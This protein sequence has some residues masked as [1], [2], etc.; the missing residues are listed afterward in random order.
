MVK[1]KEALYFSKLEDSKVKCHLCPNLCT[2][3]LNK[4]GKCNVRINID[5]KLYSMIYSLTTSGSRDPIE[6]KPLYHFLPGTCAYSFGTIGC[7]LFCEFCQNYHISRANPEDYKYGLN[8]LSPSDAVK[9]AQDSSCPSVAYTYNE[10]IIWFEWVLDTAK[11]MQKQG[12]KNILVTNGYIEEEPLRE[13]L[14]FIDAAN[15]DLKGDR[16]FYR[17]MCK[18]SHQEAVLRTCEIMKENRVHLEITNLIVTSKNDSK[19]QLQELIDFIV[20]KLGY[21][22][23]LHFS[24]YFPNYKLDL[25]PTPVEKLLLARNLALKAGL[26]YVYLGNVRDAEHSNTYCK[27]CGTLLINRVGYFT[28]IT[29]LTKDKKCS[30]CQSLTDVIWE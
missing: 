15:V 9:E 3:S 29:N 2:I 18:V 14:P 24:R 7:N 23:P 8:S 10:P 16:N 13:L 4:K 28:K 1:F 25:P 30:K 11:L 17:E 12:L 6:K 22:I 5:G 21:D 26:H 19:E 20:E 27:N